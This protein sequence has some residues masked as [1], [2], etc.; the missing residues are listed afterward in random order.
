MLHFLT[1]RRIGLGLLAAIV[2]VDVTIS[3]LIFAI[4]FDYL[5]EFISYVY[6]IFMNDGTDY[7]LST[8]FHDTVSGIVGGFFQSD[9]SVLFTASIIPS[10]WI[11]SFCVATALTRSIAAT[12]PLGGVVLYVLD[13]DAHPVRSVGVVTALMV[14]SLFLAIWIGHAVVAAIYY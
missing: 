8:S 13:I 3:L 2:V 12:A 11:W 4:P 1:A 5:I 7:G 6:T 10:L 9:E 14:F